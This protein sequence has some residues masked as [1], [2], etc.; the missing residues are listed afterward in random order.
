[1]LKTSS[2]SAACAPCTTAIRLTLRLLRS[3]LVRQSGHYCTTYADQENRS[4]AAGT[5]VRTCVRARRHLVPLPRRCPQFPI[6]IS[7]LR[8]KIVSI[9][10]PAKA[11]T[12]GA[13]LIG[14][15]GRATR[16]WPTFAGTGVDWR[17]SIDE[18]GIV[19][20]SDD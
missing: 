1:M 9:T 4:H 3:H 16:A 5:R 13:R 12:R 19:R 7:R 20:S 15:L 2:V 17:T 18:S 10:D 11:A 14:F 6:D 8:H